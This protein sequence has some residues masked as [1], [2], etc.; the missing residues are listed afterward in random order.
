MEGSSVV[1]AAR[2]GLPL[3]G[4]DLTD[5]VT[6][7]ELPLPPGLCIRPERLTNT[8]TF[9]ADVTQPHSKQD[10][11]SL[12]VRSQSP[13]VSISDIIIF[14]LLPSISL[15]LTIRSRMKD[16]Y[17][18]TGVPVGAVPAVATSLVLLFSAN[19]VSSIL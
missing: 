1:Q 7:H 9:D 11:H 14:C 6:F 19:V 2:V 10:E 18:S 15:Y 17:K 5:P 8:E 12:S 3:W 4:P 13:T 16:L